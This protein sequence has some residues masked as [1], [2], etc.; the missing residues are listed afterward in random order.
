V[1]IQSHVELENTRKKLRELEEVYEKV[2]TGPTDNVHVRELTLTSL[3]KLMNQFFEEIV[4]YESHV[5]LR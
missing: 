5:G 1:S 3:K 2:K 4:R